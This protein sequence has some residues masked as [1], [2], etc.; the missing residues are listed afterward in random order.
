MTICSWKD[1]SVQILEQHIIT[2][3]YLVD[4]NEDK[5]FRVYFKYALEF[6]YSNMSDTITKIMT[7]QITFSQASGLN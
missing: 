3:K 7:A 5:Q 2:G 4:L 6:K 1:H